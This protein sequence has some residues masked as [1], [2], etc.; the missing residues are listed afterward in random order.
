MKKDE[1][2]AAIRHLCQEFARLRGIPMDGSGDPSFGDFYRW[3]RDNYPSYLKFRSRLSPRD[4]V[5]RWW[6]NEFRQGWRD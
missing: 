6:A 5:E 4:E 1:A 3:V 2:E